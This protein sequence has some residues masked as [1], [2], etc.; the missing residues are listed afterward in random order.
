MYNYKIW[1][2]FPLIWFFNSCGIWLIGHTS[3][4]SWK[5]L[6]VLSKIEWYQLL[7]NPSLNEEVYRIGNISLMNI[8]I[9]WNGTSGLLG[10]ING[11][12]FPRY[13]CC[14]VFNWLSGLRNWPKTNFRLLFG[15]I[16]LDTEISSD[17]ER[18]FFIRKFV[19]KMDSNQPAP[20]Q[21]YKSIRNYRSL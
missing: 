10:C 20:A 7:C 4:N 13:Q 14:S 6:L 9:Q 17:K 15:A 3:L 5:Q 8:W 2:E 11:C 16:S 19:V 18:F 12:I 1:N 21:S